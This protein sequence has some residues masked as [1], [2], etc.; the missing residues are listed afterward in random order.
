MRIDIKHSVC[1]MHSCIS[2][3]VEKVNTN[4]S[5]HV[6]NVHN[7]VDSIYKKNNL[8]NNNFKKHNSQHKPI[9]LLY[10]RVCL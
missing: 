1:S 3:I 8:L 5:I 6:Y 2:G 9:N 10:I 7:N 4:Y